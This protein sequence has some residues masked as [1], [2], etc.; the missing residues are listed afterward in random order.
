MKKGDFIKKWW[1][2]GMS[3]IYIKNNENLAPTKSPI[4][5]RFLAVF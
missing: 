2:R 3:H 5:C 1:E 4:F